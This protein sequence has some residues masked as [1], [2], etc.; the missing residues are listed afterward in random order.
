MYQDGLTVSAQSLTIMRLHVTIYSTNVDD[1]IYGE[2]FMDS[3]ADCLI[4]TDCSAVHMGTSADQREAFRRDSDR[5][6]Q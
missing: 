2:W 1:D 5:R 3:Y 4:L 6:N